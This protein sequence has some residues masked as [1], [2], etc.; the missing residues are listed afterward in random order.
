MLRSSK[1][2]LLIAGWAAVLL[3]TAA[4]AADLSTHLTLGGGARFEDGHG[5]PSLDLAVRADLLLPRTERAPWGIGPTVEL[6]TTGFDALD[7]AGGLSLFVETGDG[8]GLSVSAGA[9]QSL[10]GPGR[11]LHAFTQ[12]GWGWREPM[13]TD[14]PTFSRPVRRS[15]YSSSAGLYVRYARS[16]NLEDRSVLT[17]GIEFDPETVVELVDILSWFIH[18]PTD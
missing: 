10:F 14:A 7:L 11:G 6:C 16:L 17:A 13:S 15:L 9:G 18:G 2:S 1:L 12:L 4:G 5:R 8:V 3:P